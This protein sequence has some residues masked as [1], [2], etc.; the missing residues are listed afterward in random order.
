L[1]NPPR[2]FA[3][4]NNRQES[5]SDFLWWRIKRRSKNI[6][7]PEAYR[8]PLGGNDPAYL[9]AN[10]SDITLTWIGHATVLLQIAGKN[11]LIDPHF[12][13]RAFPVQWAG[14]R[15]ATPPGLA[16]KDLPP[17]D[18]VFITHD[19]YDS[20]DRT[21]IKQLRNREF[22]NRIIYIVPLRIGRL[23]SSWGIYNIIE[24][25]W[26]QELTIAGLRVAAI[27]LRHWSKR[28]FLDT[29][30]RLWAGWVIACGDFRFCFIGDTGYLA[31]LFQKIG[32][33]YGPFDLAA[34]PIGS[35][36]PRWL[37]RRF[38]INPE[39]AIL[40]HRDIGSAKSVAIHWGTFVLTDEP[41][42]EPPAKLAAARR[43]YGL[44]EEEFLVMHHGQTLVF[45][46]PQY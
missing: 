18:F 24:F 39:E 43:D 14:P 27:P 13:S 44:T 31:A 45:N 9:L 15:R 4:P 40:V 3:N 36:E 46:S 12:S 32:E 1:R 5:F 34:I 11:I 7:A 19:H 37:L 33:R 23:L 8:F 22:G 25:A 30:A 20:L 2:R 6:P 38:H 29:N 28:G 10:R 21:T 41:L 35:Y 42:D 16:F 17:I 26:W